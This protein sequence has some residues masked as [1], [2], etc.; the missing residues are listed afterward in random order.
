MV[1]GAQAGRR[2][3]RADQLGFGAGQHRLGLAR[4]GCRRPACRGIAGQRP[5]QHGASQVAGPEL[6]RSRPGRPSATTS[7]THANGGRGGWHRPARPAGR[8][9][10]AHT[11]STS[12]RMDRPSS[13]AWWKVSTASVRR[14]ASGLRR[15]PR[16]LGTRAGPAQHA[17]PDQR[18]LG[19]LEALAP[20][21]AQERLERVVRAGGR[22]GGSS[23]HRTSNAAR[24]IHRLDQAVPSSQLEAGPQHRVAPHH[25]LPGRLERLGSQ[26]LR[27]VQGDLQDVHAVGGAAQVVEDHA[28]LGGQCRIALGDCTTA[29]PFAPCRSHTAG[30]W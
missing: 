30:A 16:R 17:Q 8:R 18:R 5:G 15:R 1:L 19:R 11:S 23:C 24:R 14:G 25:V 4:L 9:S 29:A 3:S 7:G 2:A 10:N 20:V 27:P 21:G 26:R 13:T 12:S 6:L 28:V 22:R